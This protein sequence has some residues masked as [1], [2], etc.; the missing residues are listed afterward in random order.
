M[1]TL[2][3]YI[4]LLGIPLMVIITLII[5]W[6]YRRVWFKYILVFYILLIALS[7]VPLIKKEQCINFNGSRCLQSV[8]RI[9]FWNYLNPPLLY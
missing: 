3:G 8:R 9:N 7:M 4:I 1:T 6:K 2:T 5:T